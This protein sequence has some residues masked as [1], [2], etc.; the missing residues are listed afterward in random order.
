MELV[1]CPSV[2][3]LDE[4]TTGLDSTT[5]LELVHA[6]RSIAEHRSLTI[7]AVIHQPSSKIFN[8]FNDVRLER[9]F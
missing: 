4:P 9:E 3:F 7:A 2:L 8:L 6:L 1:L 5:S